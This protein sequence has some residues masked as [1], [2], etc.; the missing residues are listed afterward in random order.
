MDITQDEEL[1]EYILDPVI[2]AERYDEPSR[3]FRD[4]LAEK[5]VSASSIRDACS[6]RLT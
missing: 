2:L 1:R 5:V 6:S 3:P 4:Y